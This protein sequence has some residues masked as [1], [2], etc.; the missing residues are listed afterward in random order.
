MKLMIL[1]RTNLWAHPQ[2]LKSDYKKPRESL[3]YLFLKGKKNIQKNYIIKGYVIGEY[4]TKH[5]SVERDTFN[6]DKEKADQFY[7]F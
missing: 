5:V 4:L 7:P 6:F 1:H 3:F 2:V